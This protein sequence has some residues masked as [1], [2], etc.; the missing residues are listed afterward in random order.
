M[1]FQSQKIAQRDKPLPVLLAWYP[2]CLLFLSEK[3]RL[4]W[5]DTL[6]RDPLMNLLKAIVRLLT[7]FSYRDH[8]LLMQMGLICLHESVSVLISVR[9][10]SLDHLIA[11]W[12]SALRAHHRQ[13]RVEP[14]P[15]WYR[16][17]WEPELVDETL[18]ILELEIDQH[19][20]GSDHVLFED[21]VAELLPAYHAY[22]HICQEIGRQ[23]HRFSW[24]SSKRVRLLDVEC[25]EHHFHHLCT[26]AQDTQPE[27]ET[28][29]AS[30]FDEQR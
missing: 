12:S 21:E 26:L 9:L 15:S 4:V 28:E 8:S 13:M 19:F 2:L 1:A 14:L 22:E 7:R 16:W 24:R 30:S 29:M 27:S 23:F 3:E 10:H 18:R 5:Q 6:A 17:A 20:Y 25:L 11:T